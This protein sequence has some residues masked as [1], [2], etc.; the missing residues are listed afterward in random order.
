MYGLG[1]RNPLVS[2]CHDGQI[3]ALGHGTEENKGILQFTFVLGV[4]Q[5]GM[6]CSC[7]ASC[8]DGHKF[9]FGH[10]TEVNKGICYLCAWYCPGRYALLLNIN[11]SGWFE[12][13]GPGHRTEVNKGIVEFTF[14]LGIGIWYC[15][16]S[17]SCTAPL[18]S[19]CQT[20]G[21]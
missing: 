6:H 19:R 17:A 18:Q 11:L 2:L 5:A 9:A 14:V 16:G 4:V 20:C 13:C 21:D 1:D 3:F 10:R 8:Q 7:V 15:P 12:I